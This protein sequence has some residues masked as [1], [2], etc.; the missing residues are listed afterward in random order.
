MSVLMQKLLNR[1]GVVFD[2][3]PADG[4]DGGG[5]TGSSGSST[6][7]K[8]GGDGGQG[9]TG[10]EGASG[11]DGD[12]G[13]GKPSDGEAKLLKEVMEKKGKIKELEKTID[14]LNGQIKKFDGIDPEAV[15]ALLRERQEAE[16]KK[17]EAQGNFEAVKKQMI[18]AHNAELQSE[19]TKSQQALD[20]ANKLKQQIGELT[21]GNAFGNSPF[22]REEMALTPAKTRIVYGPHFE[23]DAEHGRVVGYDKPAG[24]KGRSPLVDGNGE[25]L[26]FEEALKKL[27][28][29][30]P[31]REHLLKGKI[32]T[33]ANSRT[34]GTG[35][36]P[37]PAQEMSARDK[38]LAGLKAGLKK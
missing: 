19:R 6:D 7:D 33:G 24:T 37:Q 18:D 34:E 17:L 14:D 12:K 26:P 32:K 10:D 3:A 5:A 13:K 8:A 25:P 28:E 29:A 27:V 11:S 1:Q 16:T 38:I 35:A 15:R 31:D 21:V 23:F 36:P 4:G 20:E 9:G 22:I 2:Q 30:D